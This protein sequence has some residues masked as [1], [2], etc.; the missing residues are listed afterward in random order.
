[1]SLKYA[2]AFYLLGLTLG[3][4]QS[5]RNGEDLLRG[6]HNRY[7]DSCYQTVTFAVK[8]TV[9][10]RLPGRET[11]IDTGY[12]AMELPGKVRMDEEPL[13]AGKGDVFVDGTETIIDDNKIFA[14]VKNTPMVRVLGFEVP[15]GSGEDREDRERPRVRSVKNLRG[16]VGRYASV[17]RR[18]GKG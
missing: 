14:T 5:L 4:A 1:M 11:S 13:S 3:H 6:M 10:L 2:L 7:R 12:E 15:A 18:G 16:H 17:R 9:Y 8:D